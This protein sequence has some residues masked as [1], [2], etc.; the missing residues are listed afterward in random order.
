MAPSRKRRLIPTSIHEVDSVEASP[1][2][3][4]FVLGTGYVLL[5]VFLLGFLFLLWRQQENGL[6]GQSAAYFTMG[7]L[8]LLFC[9]AHLLL[10]LCSFRGGRRALYRNQFKSAYVARIG[11]W[12][13]YMVPPLVLGY[14]L[15]GIAE[16]RDRV[17]LHSLSTL[18]WIG[19]LLQ[20]GGI[21]FWFLQL[22]KDSHEGLAGRPLGESR[23]ADEALAFDIVRET[24]HRDRLLRLMVV[25][26]SNIIVWTALLLHAGGLRNAVAEIRGTERI[27]RGA[28]IVLPWP[29]GLASEAPGTFFFSCIL[30][31]LPPAATIS[32][33]LAG[34]VRL[35]IHR[36][37][38]ED[39]E[40]QEQMLAEVLPNYAAIR[41]SLDRHACGAR[42]RLVPGSWRYPTTVRRIGSWPV[43]YAIQL[44][45][46]DVMLPEE[47]LLAIVWHECGHCKCEEEL[48]RWLG[49]RWLLVW[50]EVLRWLYTDSVEEEMAA[51]LFCLRQMRA[52]T[53]LLTVLTRQTGTVRMD[54]RVTPMRF[55]EALLWFWSAGF[56]PYFHPAP[57]TRLRGLQH[58]LATDRLCGLNA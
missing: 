47:E 22:Q 43:R 35:Q 14:L 10:V 37:F 2:F 7:V 27:G 44:S 23:I 38:K 4:L 29:Q 49:M 28:L 32:L 55:R 26:S 53:P 56:T 58:A 39:T 40:A 13:A 6:R 54:A 24:T 9:G 18:F 57:E 3:T 41:R 15:S 8:C 19:P 21:A 48:P 52:A 31:L 16:F 36:L 46:F 20:W 11:L 50:G 30:M 12:S 34:A 5:F 42:V 1:W 17:D 33:K 45:A 25:L 51:D